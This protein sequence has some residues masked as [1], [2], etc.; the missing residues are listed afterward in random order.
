MAKKSRR[1]ESRPMRSYVF[2]V[3][4]EPD[5]FEDGRPAFHA[6]CPALPGCHTWGHTEAEALANIQE[7]VELYIDDLVESGK[8]VPVDPAK[9]TV[10]V[11]APAVVVNL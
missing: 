6:S 4:I 3:K 9:G 7:A 10:E 5:T 1:T 2:R 11:A 8:T